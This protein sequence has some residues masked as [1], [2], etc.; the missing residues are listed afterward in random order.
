[1]H[2]VFSRKYLE[3]CSK[4]THAHIP[5]YA[6][7]VC[8]LFPERLDSP[9]PSRD[10]LARSLSCGFWKGIGHPSHTHTHTRHAPTDVL[11]ARICSRKHNIYM[12]CST[13]AKLRHISSRLMV[14]RIPAAPMGIF[15]SKGT[16]S[17]EIRRE[18][19]R[20]DGGRGGGREEEKARRR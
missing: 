11:R 15:Q 12:N 5:V 7:D 3:T 2:T 4:H 13:Y 1:M 10:L 8:A 16:E 18:V 14:F 17:G 6:S 20:D 19:K 9:E